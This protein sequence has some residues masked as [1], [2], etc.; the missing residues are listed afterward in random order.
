MIGANAWSN[1]LLGGP[2][3]QAI[4]L[5]AAFDGVA[6]SDAYKSVAGWSS[7]L[8]PMSWIAT[9][10]GAA[11][12]TVGLIASPVLGNRNE[13]TWMG[14]ATHINSVTI[15]W[16][17]GSIVTRGGAAQP[18]AGAP[19]YNLGNFIFLD[20]NASLTPGAVVAHEAGHT[21][22]VAAFGGIFHFIGF[23]DEMIWP[24]TGSAALAERW[25]ESNDPTASWSDPNDQDFQLGG[26]QAW[27][28]MWT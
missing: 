26:P 22:N 3:L 28:L 11:L 16:Q 4:N 20:P 14:R 1:G 10:I 13:A 15:E 23:I 18:W 7:W 9:G 12:F 2:A 21:L 24:G 5:L 19:G 27:W 6:G 17:T 8:S 25:A